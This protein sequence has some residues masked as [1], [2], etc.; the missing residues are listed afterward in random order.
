[1]EKC[2]LHA[3]SILE[4][5]LKVVNKL[6]SEGSPVIHL[7]LKWFYSFMRLAR[8]KYKKFMSDLSY[9]SQT[10]FSDKKYPHPLGT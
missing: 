9:K 6:K 4:V 10:V 3:L 1:M 8:T 2:P 7:Q 5:S